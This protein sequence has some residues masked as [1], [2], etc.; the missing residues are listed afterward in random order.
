MSKIPTLDGLNADQLAHITS[1]CGNSKFD[2]P[3][4]IFR[5]AC[6]GHDLA[7]WVGCTEDDRYL[8]DLKFY[9]DM[10]VLAAKQPWYK[11]FFY[12]GM[13]YTYYVGVRRFTKKYFFFGEAK[14]TLEDL[15]KEMGEVKKSPTA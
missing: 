15:D 6:Q 1:G 3:D 11:R 4:W 2:V 12:Y 7:Y 14:R 10:M 8:A 13:A 9:G 5:S